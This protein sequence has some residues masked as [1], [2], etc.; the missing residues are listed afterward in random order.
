ME[1][2]F[3]VRRAP[4]AKPTAREMYIILEREGWRRKKGSITLAC[5][6]I[7]FGQAEFKSS[8]FFLSKNQGSI[9]VSLT[10]GMPT[11]ATRWKKGAKG[12]GCLNT[13]MIRRG[14]YLFICVDN[15]KRAHLG[16][17]NSKS[18]EGA[19]RGVTKF[20]SFHPAPFKVTPKSIFRFFLPLVHHEHLHPSLSCRCHCF[21]VRSIRWVHSIVDNPTHSAMALLQWCVY[22]WYSSLTILHLH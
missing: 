20:F 16:E 9:H 18:G 2:T 12:R 11:G 1:A 15:R 5:T 14:I 3:W 22:V 13:M 19:T 6:S 8:F 21:Q 7:K 10:G 4:A 17:Y